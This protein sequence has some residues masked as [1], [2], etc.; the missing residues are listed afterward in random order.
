M[1]ENSDKTRKKDSIQFKVGL[2]MILAVVL[3]LATCYLSYRNLSSVVS[4]IKI[5]VNPQL[6]LISIRE[7]SMDLEKAEN[8]VRLYTITKNPVDLKSYY[9]VVSKID[10]KVTRLRDQ[11]RNDSILL[12][13]TRS[14]G[15][16]IE[17][18]IILWNQLL[19]LYKDDKVAEYLKKLSDQLDSVSEARQKKEGILKRVFGRNQ[20][21]QI[22]DQ[23]LRSDIDSLVIQDRQAKDAMIA[24]ESKIAYTSS[25]LK[26]KFYDL[27]SK[28]ES[29]VTSSISAKAKSAGKVAGNTYTWLIMLA[30]SGGLLAIMVLLIIIRYVRKAYAY[31]EALEISRA[32][33]EKLARTK[34]LFMANMSH[35]IRTPVTAISG[36]TEQLLREQQDENIKGPL[37]IIKSSS[38]H[39]I[40]II[41]DIL[42]FSKLQNDKLV[43]E[44]IDFR[45]GPVL[46]EV[47][48]LFENKAKQNNTVLSFSVDNNTPPVL[49]G[50]PHRLKQ[51]LMN[52]V[53]NSI[54]FTKNG[55]VTFSIQSFNKGNDELELV[56]EVS[57]TGI[58]IDESK[59]EMVFEDFTQA[60]M[61]TA[62]KYGGTGLGLSIVKKLVELHNGTIDVKSRKNQG[63]T[64]VC[65]LPYRKGTGA[66]DS[67]EEELP[68]QVP[69]ELNGLNALV[70]DDEEYN[71][72]LFRKILEKWKINFSEACTGMDAL[73][74]LKGNKYDLLFMDMLMP[75]LDGLKTTKFIREEMKISA[76]EMPII[77][78]SAA[79][80]NEELGK[81]R[82][83][84][85]N[86]FLRKPFSEATL[87]KAIIE[88]AGNRAS[89][90]A[91]SAN[92]SPASDSSVNTGKIDL[93]NLYH[94]A[95]GDEKFVRQMLVSFEETTR[96]GLKEIEA[97]AS[98][99][100]WELTANSAHRLLPP[101]KHL[102][103][104][105]LYNL[106]HEIENNS[107]NRV[108]TGAVKLLAERSLN[109]FEQICQY[110]D[111]YL[112]KM[113]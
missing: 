98:D 110:L 37:K 106:L 75:G 69:P 13:Q 25:E 24:R 93:K 29:E 5:D 9:S 102:G 94:I 92:E 28:M 60:E 6:K 67:G 78:I 42:D 85:I 53:S 3:L 62:R 82:N 80:I 101:C 10:D 4:S 84:G 109:E 38:D 71:R 58:G 18:N 59:L 33:A 16:L 39:L 8:G 87:L 12:R 100:N 99:E 36:F 49:S 47:N 83:A 1:L 65:R 86:S 11:C 46:E 17:E 44:K 74:L 89:A 50:D 30:V 97:S 105:D 66:P 64:I 54:K 35:E 22:D 68:V 34:E 7:I 103:A 90:Q 45:P 27:I 81:Y 56:V 26:G 73:E 112:A 70:V 15:R 2:L 77:F 57:D 43:L 104:T 51:I 76:T 72:L 32:E 14:I 91:Q 79:R 95:A 23:A 48:A 61:S 63:T 19:E 21:P 40:K 111:T 52:L 31:Q 96:R 113:I 55:T 107:R 41:D 88:T 108:N 20:K